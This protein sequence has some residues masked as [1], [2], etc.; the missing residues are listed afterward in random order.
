MIQYSSSHGA[1][2]ITQEVRVEMKIIKDNIMWALKENDTALEHTEFLENHMPHLAYPSPYPVNIFEPP[3]FG[4][5]KP[6]YTQFIM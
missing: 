5:Y 4:Q 2:I 1:N 3:L 6:E